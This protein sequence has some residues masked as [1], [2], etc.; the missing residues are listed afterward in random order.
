MNRTNP[1]GTEGKKVLILEDDPLIQRCVEICMKKAGY[2]PEVYSS[3]D[4]AIRAVREGRYALVITDY[5]LSTRLT[6]LDFLTF[7]REENFRIPAVFMSANNTDSLALQAIKLGAFAFL[8]KP[9]DA[10]FLLATCRA[11]MA[12]AA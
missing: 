7:L 4:E 10:A 8:P 5:K 12:C 9:F 2:H 1:P 6:G 11:A 3:V